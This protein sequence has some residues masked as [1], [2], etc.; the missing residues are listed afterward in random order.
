MFAL[1]SAGGAGGA[2]SIGDILQLGTEML[3]W[4]I[5]SMGSVVNFIFSNPAILFW[6]LIGMVGAVVGMLM[7]IW[8]SA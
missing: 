6:F 2:A 4:F 1:L 8:H 7:R 5:A 3:T